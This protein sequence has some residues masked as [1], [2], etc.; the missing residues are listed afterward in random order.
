MSD[1][2]YYDI[3]PLHWNTMHQ[4]ALLAIFLLCVMA[5]AGMAYVIWQKAYLRGWKEGHYRGYRKGKV[6][7]TE[8]V[9]KLEDEIQQLRGLLQSMPPVA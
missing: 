3:N 5:L 2:K 4:L 6:A 9:H 1:I 7:H 8:R